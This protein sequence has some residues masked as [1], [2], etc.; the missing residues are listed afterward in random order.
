MKI[1]LKACKVIDSDS[2]FHQKTKDI[3]IEN[4]IITQI[5]NHIDT[6]ADQVVEFDNLHV[7]VGWFDAKV[8]FSDPGNEIKEDVL[9][10][11]KSAELGGFTAVATTP[12]TQPKITNKSQINYLIN[13]AQFSPVTVHPFGTL[14]ENLEGKN[15]SE[16]FDMKSAGA[17]AFTDNHKMVSAGIMYRAL[18]YAKN[19][20]GKII[21]F[22]YDKSIF[23]KGQVNESKVSVLTGLKAM[24]SIS[25]Y[26]VVERDLTLAEYTESPIHFTGL[27]CKQSVELVRKAKAKGIKVTADVY[28]HQLIFTDKEVLD[29]DTNYKV[30]PPLRTEKDK[31]ALV[32]GVKDGTI[33]F[34]C[35][36]H[37]P[38]D[39]ESKDIEFGNAEFGIIGTQTL[40][41]VLNSVEEFSLEQ[42]I[43]LISKK[44]REIFNVMTEGITLNAKAN[45]TLFIPNKTWTLTQDKIASKSKN[46]PFLNKKLTG[47]AV[48]LVNKGFLSIFE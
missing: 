40:F 3:L 9:S 11:L 19:F 2:K 43:N 22:P 32:N 21:S 38:E 6:T 10:G 16:Y 20:N 48:G 26:I 46:T 1:L 36:D 28:V 33:D 7:S 25:E 42:K 24:P 23:G 14:T 47:K 41:S 34:V 13:K 15:I 8:N 5:D 35:S 4:E 37:T 45:L 12:D 27:S 44:P 29:F 18:L 30:L 39:V 31:Q 17:I